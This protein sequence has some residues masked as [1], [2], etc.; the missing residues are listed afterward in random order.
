MLGNTFG[1]LESRRLLDFHLGESSSGL[2]GC[3]ERILKANGSSIFTRMGAQVC[4][5]GPAATNDDHAPSLVHWPEVSPPLAAIFEIV[6][7]LLA[8]Y[9]LALWRGIVP[10]DFRMPPKLRLWG[11]V[12]HCFN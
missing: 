7:V 2:L 12:Y 11:R 1:Q 10:G 3:S 4:W 8:A 9:R 5:I 6:P